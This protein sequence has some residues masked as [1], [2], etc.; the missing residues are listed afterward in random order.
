M[1]SL[2][3][4]PLCDAPPL[5]LPS[6]QCFSH[7]MFDVRTAACS[8]SHY[9]AQKCTVEAADRHTAAIVAALL[10]ARRERNP[11]LSVWTLL[12]CHIRTTIAMLFNDSALTSNRRCS[13]NIIVIRFRKLQLRCSRAD[14]IHEL[15]SSCIF[16][17]LCCLCDG[18]WGHVK[19]VVLG[20]G[21]VN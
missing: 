6:P 3:H 1:Q 5:S 12:W 8:A 11:G 18:W 2:V 7:D 9:I 19:G 13:R 10:E 15:C 16:A 21:A 14:Q 20:K 4:A 17:F